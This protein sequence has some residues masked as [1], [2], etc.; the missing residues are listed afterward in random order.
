L[1]AQLNSE[2]RAVILSNSDAWR[3][4]TWMLQHCV[5]DAW[6]DHAAVRASGMLRGLV[7]AYVG[8]VDA[9]AA[10]ILD[11]LP[12]RV[13]LRVRESSHQRLRMEPHNE[14]RRQL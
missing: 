3:R 11:A 12:E 2:W 10:K 8:R 13:D 1:V 9:D 5:D 6:R 7:Q 4:P 14:Q